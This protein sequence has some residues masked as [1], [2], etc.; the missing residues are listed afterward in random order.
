[1][2]P[3]QIDTLLL[4]AYSGWSIERVFVLTIQEANGL[5][6]EP[7]AEDIAAGRVTRTVTADGTTF[8]WQTMLDGMFRVHS[9]AQPLDRRLGARVILSASGRWAKAAAARRGLRDVPSAIPRPA[10]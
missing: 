1:M 5:K 9:G 7:L 3:L 4:L 2:S 10:A 6:I 8:D